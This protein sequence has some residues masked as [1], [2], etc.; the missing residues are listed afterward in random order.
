MS[1]DNNPILI[2]GAGITG[3][4]LGQAL[5]QRNIPF[6]IYERDPHLSSR[7]QG[8]AITLHWALSYLSSL[9]PPNVLNR[10]E[11][12][13]VD[14]DVAKHDTG[15]FLYLNLKSGDIHW[16]IPPNKRWRVNR[17][18]LRSALLQGI[19]GHVCWGR[20][21]EGVQFAHEN[22]GDGDGKP[23]VLYRQ[24]TS[25]PQVGDPDEIHLSTPFTQIIGAEG[26]RSLIRQFLCPENYKNTPLPVRFTGVSVSLNQDEV[27]PLRRL[28][29]LLFQGTHPDTGVFFWGD[30]GGLYKVQL[31]TSWPVRNESSDQV[32][33]E[34]AERLHNMKRR[35]QGFVSFLCDTIQSIPD[36]TEVIEV[37]LADWEGPPET[38]RWNNYGGRITLAGDA[39]HAMTMYRGEAANHGILDVYHLVS[40]IE[41]IHSGQ[42]RENAINEYEDE[43]LCGSVEG[44]VLRLVSG[45]V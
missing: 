2:V 41:K 33:A 16:R 8:W 39:A 32:P 6:S 27:A 17:E 25:E 28:D 43:M 23:R 9:L 36:G 45:R 4:I 11:N 19:E 29:P 14:Q 37:T 34:N 38:E 40:A 12:V 22:N 31:G 13:Q 18:R 1:S 24:T 21:V 10:I 42:D 26:P 30:Q 5:K 44:L 20:K 15:N 3:L 7:H 35:S